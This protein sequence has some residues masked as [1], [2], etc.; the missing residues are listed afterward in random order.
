MHSTAVSIAAL[1]PGFL[2]P[3]AAALL[4]HRVGEVGQVLCLLS[5]IRASCKTSG[6]LSCERMLNSRQELY[7]CGTQ[8]GV[9]FGT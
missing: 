6:I 2:K 4:Y 8:V 9:H 7:R 1:W 3:L 5:Q